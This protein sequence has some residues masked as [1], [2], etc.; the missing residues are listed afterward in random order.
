[1]NDKAQLHTMEGLLAAILMT[2]TVLMITQ[3]TAIVTPQNELAIDVQL[4]QIG[5]DTLKVIDIAPQTSIIRNNLT[6]CVASWDTT[7][8]ASYPTNNLE[9][10]DNSISNLMPE[11]LYN[12]N[13]A[14]TRNGNLTVK[15]VIIHGQP[16]DNAVVV[17]HYVTL[18]NE[19]VKTMGGGWNLADDEIKVVEV[20]MT[21]WKV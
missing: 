21:T 3:S 5:S 16:A 12:V 17:R 13:F 4:E 11:I 10:L 6:E 19:T 15:K 9:I 8:E 7:T 2:M 14:Y 20:R 1:L 18:T